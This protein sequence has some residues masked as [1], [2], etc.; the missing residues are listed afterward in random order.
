MNIVFSLCFVIALTLSLSLYLSCTCFFSN[1]LCINTAIVYM[2]RFYAFHSFTQ[3]HQNGIAMAS[4]FLAAKVNKTYKHITLPKKKKKNNQI[5]NIVE[6][7]QNALNTQLTKRWKSNHESWSLLFKWHTYA[8]R[9]QLKPKTSRNS[10]P[11]KHKTLFSMKTFCCKRW[12]LMW[13]L[14]IRTR[15]SSKQFN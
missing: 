14:I 5:Q 6:T 8:Y 12:V 4:L 3:F 1:Q 2:H 9:T 15:M 10:A 13:P 7:I 11:S